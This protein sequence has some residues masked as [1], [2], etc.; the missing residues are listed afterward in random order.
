[1]V[2][3][4][5]EMFSLWKPMDSH[6]HLFANSCS[7][8]QCA[9]IIFIHSGHEKERAFCDSS[10]RE[11][12]RGYITPGLGITGDQLQFVVD[13]TPTT[14]GIG[15]EYK[16]IERR[17]GQYAPHLLLLIKVHLFHSTKCSLRTSAFLDNK[18]LVGFH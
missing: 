7:S 2:P 1:M 4:S 8:A 3:P 15:L 9:T 5:E 12:L 10:S 14:R 17:E 6:K 11:L 18:S 13:T 16:I